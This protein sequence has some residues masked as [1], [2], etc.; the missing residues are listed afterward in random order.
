MALRLAKKRHGRYKPNLVARCLVA[1]IFGCG[2]NPVQGHKYA[3]AG[4]AH[5]AQSSQDASIS[6][7]SESP[8]ECTYIEHH[9]LTCERPFV[10][11]AG[12]SDFFGVEKIFAR[13]EGLRYD[14]TFNLPSA[15]ISVM[16]E[17]C[18]RVENI[19][20]SEGTSISPRPGGINISVRLAAEQGS[21]WAY[22]QFVDATCSRTCVAGQSVSGTLSENGMLTVGT[23]TAQ[24]SFQLKNFRQSPSQL[25]DVLIL[26]EVLSPLWRIHNTPEWLVR[27]AD[28]FDR[29][30]SI[31][32]RNIDFASKRA[33]ITI[34]EEVCTAR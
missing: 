33:D 25:V 24:R 32:L 14:R 26:D 10:I 11:K 13:L 20:L 15:L 19:D 1:G 34:N 30:F 17:K 5:D 21:E 8:N 18:R 4:I 16:D 22:L 28:F 3:D 9:D 12:A 23:S 27:T 7:A 29:K 6:D 31:E 2:P